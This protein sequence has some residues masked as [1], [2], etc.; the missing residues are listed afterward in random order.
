VPSNAA[1]HRQTTAINPD[2]RSGLGLHADAHGGQRGT[3]IYLVP[4]LTPDQRRA[5]LRRMRQA[6]RLG[7]RP[8]ISPVNLRFALAV[9]RVRFALRTSRL[10]LERLPA[11]D[12]RWADNA[13]DP[14]RVAFLV[15]VWIVLLGEPI[16]L[17]KLPSQ[18]QSVITAEIA[19]GG[20]ALAITWRMLDKGKR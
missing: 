15:L 1:R 6:G 7:I 18:V 20:L 13:L 9:S 14:A 10:A 12:I 19:E 5:A 4:G 2:E 11:P 8:K 16:A 3:V 17:L